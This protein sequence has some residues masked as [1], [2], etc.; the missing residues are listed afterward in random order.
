MQVGGGLHDRPI[1]RSVNKSC[2]G[3]HQHQFSPPTLSAASAT[4][5]LP[6][7]KR[8][9]KAALAV[10]A[11]DEQGIEGFLIPSYY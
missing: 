6:A 10:D 8:W 1:K 11:R 3:Y 4:S 2:N 7:D 9:V 5:R